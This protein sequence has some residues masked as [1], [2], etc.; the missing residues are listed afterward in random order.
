MFARGSDRL[1]AA[2]P[3]RRDGIRVAAFN[4]RFE[5]EV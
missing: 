1:A 2:G 5:I 3:G 4:R